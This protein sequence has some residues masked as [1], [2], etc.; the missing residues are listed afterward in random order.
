VY[1]LILNETGDEDAAQ[2]AARQYATQ[3]KI[4]EAMQAK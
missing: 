4:L 2:E 1:E 3:Q